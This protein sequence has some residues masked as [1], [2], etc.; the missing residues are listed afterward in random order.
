[1]T[2]SG[3]GGRTGSTT[4]TGI[5]GADRMPSGI[6]AGLDTAWI[7][8]GEGVREALMLHCGLAS[9]RAFLPLMAELSDGLSMTAFDF[10]GHGRSGPWDGSGDYIRRAS[11]V[12][13]SFCEGPRD[14]IGHSMGGV[15][16]LTLMT[17]RPDLIR[18]AVLVE[19]VFFAAARGTEA[20]RQHEVKDAV[21]REALHAGDPMRAAQVFTT[22]WGGGR[23]WEMVPDEQRQTMADQ[24]PLIAA[25]EPALV[26][27]SNDLLGAG[28]LEAISAP[29]LLVRGGQ[30]NP[31]IGAIF[32]RLAARLPQAQVTVI[33]GAGHMLPMTHRAQLATKIR[34]FLG[35]GGG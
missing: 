24:M 8:R 1:M 21:F 27:D 31:V 26:N 7:Q 11:E 25:T 29:V 32:D 30:A 14:V 3:S 2:I 15:T 5:W 20:H 23:P 16:A 35:T 28:R 10:P 6:R 9:G 13:E 34:E 12:A 17:R 19:P 33:E 4:S 22:I 18:S